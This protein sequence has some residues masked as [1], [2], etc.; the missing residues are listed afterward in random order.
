MSE[1]YTYTGKVIHKGEPET[2]GT[3]TKCA[4]VV[5]DNAEKYPQEVQFDVTGKAL[6]HMDKYD[7]GD[8]VEVKFDLRGRAGEGKWA[9]KWFTNLNAWRVDKAEGSES[10]SSEPSNEP[11]HGTPF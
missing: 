10:G 6:E 9:G 2:F 11:E 1:A 7:V 3:F 8:T 4:L 5:C